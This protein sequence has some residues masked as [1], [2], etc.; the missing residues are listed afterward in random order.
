[1]NKHR[2]T[3]ANALFLHSAVFVLVLSLASLGCQKIEP[4]SAEAPEAPA[5]PKSDNWLRDAPE[6]P[7]PAPTVGGRDVRSFEFLNGLAEELNE[8]VPMMV[9]AETE[10]YY[11][12][13]D[14]ATIIYNY[15][16]PNF[17]WD[18]ITDEDLQVRVRP[19]VTHAA[20]TTPETRDNFLRNG[21]TMRYVYHDKDEQYIG[22][23]DVTSDRCGSN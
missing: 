5:P 12:S 19:T 2:A 13:A 17:S 7:E 23:F 20:C 11:V 22:S 6:T 18:D 16:F 3:I 8:S 1:M 15:R 9:D 21:V 14:V 10:L 4:S